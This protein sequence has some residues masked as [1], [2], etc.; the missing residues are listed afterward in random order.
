MD[1]IERDSVLLSTDILPGDPRIREKILCLEKAMLALPAELIDELPA[2]HH[3]SAG[4]YAREL[5]IPAGC[6]LIGKIHKHTNLNIISKGDISVLTEDGVQRIQAPCTIVSP[7]GVKRVGFAH[8]EVVWTTIHGTELTDLE[9][10]E[11]AFIAKDFSDV[12]SL[13]TIDVPTLGGE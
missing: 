9:E 6:L 12:P 1:V 11:E 13:G 3:F 8:T 4:V 2:Q 7:P 5:R 10:I